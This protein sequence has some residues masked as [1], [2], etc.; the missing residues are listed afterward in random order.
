MS[1]F[2]IRSFRSVHAAT[3][4]RTFFMSEKWS[5]STFGRFRFGHQPLMKLLKKTV[6]IPPGIW[7]VAPQPTRYTDISRCGRLS[8][9][10]Y[11]KQHHSRTLVRTMLQTTSLVKRLNKRSASC[12]IHI[13]CIGTLTSGIGEKFR[14]TSWN[15]L[16]NVIDLSATPNAARIGSAFQCFQSSFWCPSRNGRND[17]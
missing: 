9:L 15:H 17:T 1:V 11:Q 6:T 8:K 7:R 4:N 2:N 12:C 3:Y 5:I 13:L 14:A 16:S 10:R